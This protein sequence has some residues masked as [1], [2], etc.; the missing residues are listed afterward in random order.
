MSK[1]A[2]PPV[3]Q[4]LTPEEQITLD[5]AIGNLKPRL[6]VFAR[7]YLLNGN[8]AADAARHAGYAASSSKNTGY[9]LLARRDVASAIDAFRK[10]IAKKTTFDFDRAAE[11]LMDSAEF[12]KSTQ[13][14]TALVRATEL[15]AK[16]H[17]HMVDRQSVQHSGNAVTF[18]LPDRHASKTIE[19][20]ADG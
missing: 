16:L 2:L 7:T 9:R 5:A 13:N 12:A 14:A 1:V 15:M 4:D 17:G 8:N 20:D 6:A 3:R 11:M 10:I 18:I 19:H